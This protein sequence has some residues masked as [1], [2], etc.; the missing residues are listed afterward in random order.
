LILAEEALPESERTFSRFVSVPERFALQGSQGWAISLNSLEL[1]KHRGGISNGV[2]M[3]GKAKAALVKTLKQ[4]CCC[5]TKLW[6][7][8]VLATHTQFH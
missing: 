5:A 3:A 1:R 6:V 8:S 7:P 2:G 4:R